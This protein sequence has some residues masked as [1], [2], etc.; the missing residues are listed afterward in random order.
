MHCTKS[1]QKYKVQIVRT[2]MKIHT[3][4]TIRRGLINGEFQTSKNKIFEK[5]S[6]CVDWYNELRN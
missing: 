2:K 6:F 4:R 3:L 5:A 1:T